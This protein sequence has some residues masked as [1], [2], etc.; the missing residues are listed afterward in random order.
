MS[1]RILIEIISIA[2]V[3]GVL[4]TATGGAIVLL[5]HSPSRRMLSVFL[6]FSGGVMVSL[7]AFDL[8]PEA[9][10]LAGTP[11]GL[12]GLVIGSIVTAGI[13]LVYPHI[14]LMS[15][16][17][18]SSR[19]LRT[20]FVVALGIALH[21]LPEGLAVGAGLR[22][23]PSLG[24]AVSMLMMLHNI[25]E[26]MAVAGP[27]L[28][29]GRSRKEVLTLSALA[30]APSVLGAAIGALAGGV[31]STLLGLAFSF[32]AGAML[33]VTFDELIPG[34]QELSEGHTGTFGAVAGVIISIILS[35]L[36]APV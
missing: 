23:N 21:D 34:A 22:S 35:R 2:A 31:S 33:F 32:A 11:V 15:Q 24:I 26:G 29:S 13:D 17:R 8:M 19:F 28:A 14:H 5:A 7:V 12:A 27:L 9:F 30:G 1:V 4:G 16:D 10:D 36:I 6:G 20:S 25:P 18:E 3:V